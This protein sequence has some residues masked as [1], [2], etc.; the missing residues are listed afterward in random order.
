M[1]QA[2]LGP[3]VHP[4]ICPLHV[5][6]SASASAMPRPNG[7]TKWIQMVKL[8]GLHWV[9]CPLAMQTV[10]TSPQV[11][12][13]H[14][15]NFPCH[16]MVGAEAKSLVLL[17]KSNT[18][19]ALLRAVAC[20]ESRGCRMVGH[21]RPCFVSSLRCSLPAQCPARAGLVKLEF[22]TP[23]TEYSVKDQHGRRLER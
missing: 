23:N 5:F 6:P 2:W 1:R 11:V 22:P 9:A 20:H 21:P 12:L 17:Q 4:L 19:M 3:L 10:V 14:S 18:T 8:H 13:Q 16:F 15:C 7:E